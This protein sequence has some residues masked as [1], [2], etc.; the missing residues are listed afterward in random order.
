M[1]CY[2]CHGFNLQCKV[3]ELTAVKNLF[4]NTLITSSECNLLNPNRRWRRKERHLSA[5]RACNKAEDLS[6]P[7][8]SHLCFQVSVKTDV[9]AVSNDYT[10]AW[11]S[12]LPEV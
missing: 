11:M 10:V 12:A 5:P 8:Q 7:K 4:G 9:P 3:T 2:R 1:H 6:V